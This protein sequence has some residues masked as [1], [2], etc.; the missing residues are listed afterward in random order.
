MGGPFN[1]KWQARIEFKLPKFSQNKTIMWTAHVDT[2]TSQYD[3]IIKTNPMAELKLIIDC[4]TC[5]TLWKDSNM[6]QP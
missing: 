5:E 3:M 6:L 2:V 1:T 4:M